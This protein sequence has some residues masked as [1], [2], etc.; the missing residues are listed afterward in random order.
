MLRKN[1]YK[2]FY[3][4]L[5]TFEIFLLTKKKIDKFQLINKKSLPSQL[6]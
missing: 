2:K 5:N 1:Y 3:T 4:M 6:C